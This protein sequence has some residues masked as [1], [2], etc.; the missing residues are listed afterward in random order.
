MKLKPTYIGGWQKGEQLYIERRNKGWGVTSLLDLAF[1]FKSVDAV[2]NSFR[3]F[4]V[5]MDAAETRIYNGFLQIFEDGPTGLRQIPRL[6]RQVSL[7]DEPA[8]LPGKQQKDADNDGVTYERIEIINV[9]L[10]KLCNSRVQLYV[11]QG[12]SGAWYFGRHI[13]LACG[14][15]NSYYPYPKFSDKF[16]SRDAALQASIKSVVGY[17]GKPPVGQDPKKDIKDVLA[18]LTTFTKT[19][20]PASQPALLPETATSTLYTRDETKILHMGFIL[21]RYDR[22]KKTVQRTWDNSRQGWAPAIPFNTYAAAKRTLKDMLKIDNV[23]EVHLDG[24]ANRTSSSKK[25]YAAGFDFYRT[26]GIIPGHGTAPRI[27]CGS[28]GWGTLEKFETAKE[29]QQAWDEL[30]KDDRALEG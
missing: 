21:V 14:S 12:D 27:K 28:K 19:L 5:Y 3:T 29:C 17:C 4:D 26:D 23:V 11:V 1:R 9:P 13:H 20:V 6:T 30:M 8:L 16:T 18:A 2:L 7:F 24:K 22:D 10:S 15:G 25:L